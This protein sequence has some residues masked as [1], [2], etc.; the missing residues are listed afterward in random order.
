MLQDR[1]RDKNRNMAGFEGA[2]AVEGSTVDKGKGKE[3][4]VEDVSDDE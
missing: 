2:T 3:V 1:G 4:F